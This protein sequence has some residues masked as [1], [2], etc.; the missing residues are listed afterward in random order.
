MNSM[1]SYGMTAEEAHENYIMDKAYNEGYEAAKKEFAKPVGKWKFV[2]RG[3]YV[4]MVCTFC[5]YVREAEIGYNV[6]AEDILKEINKGI[7]KY[8]SYHGNTGF[9]KFCENCGA[10]VRKNIL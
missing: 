3:A 7:F 8:H 5:G 4:D 9:P 1:Y 6:S 2:Q 10:D